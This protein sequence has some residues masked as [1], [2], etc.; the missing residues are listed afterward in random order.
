MMGVAAAWSSRPRRRAVWRGY[1]ILGSIMVVFSLASF[2]LYYL[3]SVAM[4]WTAI[5]VDRRERP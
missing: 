5:S 2:G 1:A 3:P 4:L